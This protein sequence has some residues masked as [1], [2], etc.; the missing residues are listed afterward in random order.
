MSIPGIQYSTYCCHLLFQQSTIFISFSSMV[1]S[2]H[3]LTFYL[4][5]VFHAP[6]SP[7]SVS[8]FFNHLSIHALPFPF[9]PGSFLY[10]FSSVFLY[11]I[12][13]S[14]TFRPS[15]SFP[16]QPYPSIIPCSLSLLSFL[17]WYTRMR[18]LSAPILK[19]ALYLLSIC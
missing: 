18:L 8:P 10:S 11:L 1:L 2:S 9:F 13:L 3:S 12:H 14:R 5:P 7:A 4:T 16:L 19:F 17:S 6:F 15:F